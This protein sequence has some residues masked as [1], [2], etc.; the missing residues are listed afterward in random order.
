MSDLRL[1]ELLRVLE[2][3]SLREKQHLNTMLK[4]VVR[5]YRQISVADVTRQLREALDNPNVKS[6]Q[7]RTDMVLKALDIAVKE[8]K[9]PPQ[10]AE[11]IIRSA[12]KG[13]VQNLDEL[14]R[15]QNPAYTFN[16]PAQVQARAVSAARKDMNTYWAHEQKRFRDDVARVTRQAIRTGLNP[17][18]A[19]DLLQKRLNV[20]RSRAVLIATDQMLTAVANADRARQRDMGIQEYLWRSMED[21]RVRPEHEALDRLGRQGHRRSWNDGGEYPGKAIRCRCRAIPILPG[22]PLPLPDAAPP[23]PLA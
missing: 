14:I 19:A 11:Q 9:L 21:A 8:L 3:A 10:R 16:D 20:S 7:A 12:V 17:D 18:Q 13:R 23:S 2:L 6:A 15:L 22:K 4:V 1:T 5:Q